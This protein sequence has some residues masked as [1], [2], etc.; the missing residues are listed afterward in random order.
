M[1]N[2]IANG[3]RHFV[4][5]V[6]WFWK[7]PYHYS[8]LVPTG[9]FWQMAS[10]LCLQQGTYNF[11]PILHTY[12]RQNCRKH[13][14]IILLFTIFIERT[15]SHKPSILVELEYGVYGLL[16]RKENQRTLRKTL[17]VRR[18]P[19]TNSI[20]LIWHGA[21][22]K[23]RPHWSEVDAL[24]TAPSLLLIIEINWN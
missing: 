9:L 24:G 4:R 12:A 1:G 22:I 21:S 3:K 6:C 8:M 11:C 23:L 13:P 17:G 14:V 7:N 15:T 16:W 10:T 18:E 5:L 2:Q 20:N 19:T